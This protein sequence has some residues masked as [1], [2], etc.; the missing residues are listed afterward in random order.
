MESKEGVLGLESPCSKPSPDPKLSIPAK[1]GSFVLEAAEG[2]SVGSQGLR[3]PP[4][5]GAWGLTRLKA[6]VHFQ[7][8]E[9]G[10][11]CGA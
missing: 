1:L 8:Q 11:R 10:F 4:E 2:L 7:V 3:F 9:G 6:S 5:E